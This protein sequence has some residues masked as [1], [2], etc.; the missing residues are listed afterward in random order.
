MREATNP[1]ARAAA[2]A[3]A[4]WAVAAAPGAVGA[5]ET[6]TG[7]LVD[8][9]ALRVCADPSNLPFSNEAGEGFENRIAELL[10]EELGVPL[11]YTFHPD[12]MGFVRNTLDAVRCD[13]IMGMATGVELVQGT[14][15]YYTSTYALVYRADRGLD[16]TSLADPALKDLTI[17][18]MA[19]TPPVTVLARN[20]LL[21]GLKPY[22]LLVDTRFH[23]PG[24]QLVEDVAA[25]KVDVGAL[26][27]P[28]AGYWAKQQA[29]PMKVVPLAGPAT[30]GERMSFRIGMG[31]RHNEID[32]KHRLNDF[33]AANQER[34]N[35]ILL[36]YGVPLLDARGRPIEH[37]G[38]DDD[39]GRRGQQQR[40]P[41]AG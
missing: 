35:A 16:I 12:T 32:W 11:A 9:S 26:W 38:D 5:A 15:P 17:G 1:L 6:A 24:R 36:D 10:A 20:G 19:Q 7:D 18:A 37:A 31:V 33:I 29:V 39:G 3:V 25:G 27:G 23:A 28:I 40:P 2:W 22:H 13:V 14:N 4:A 21:R 41:R 30:G 8:R 34:I